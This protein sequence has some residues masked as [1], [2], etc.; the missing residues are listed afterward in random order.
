MTWTTAKVFLPNH[1]ARGTPELTFLSTCAT[2]VRVC[3]YWPVHGNLYFHEDADK[4]QPF[5]YSIK[6]NQSKCLFIIYL[7]FILSILIKIFY[8]IIFI[9]K[10]N[11]LKKFKFKFKRHEIDTNCH[12]VMLIKR[13]LAPIGTNFFQGGIPFVH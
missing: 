6:K 5:D 3:N 13:N 11:N 2:D 12:Q 8:Y 9:I 4:K 7:R 10:I 1:Y